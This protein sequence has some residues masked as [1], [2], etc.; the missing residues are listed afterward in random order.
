MT[1]VGE[2]TATGVADQVPLRGMT[3]VCL[4]VPPSAFLPDERVFMSF[5]LRRTAPG[6]A[7][8]L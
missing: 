7:I 6:A 4:I 5:I 3:P 2:R 8:A 1:I